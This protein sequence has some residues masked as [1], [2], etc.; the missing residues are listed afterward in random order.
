MPRCQGTNKDGTRCRNRVSEGAQ[1]CHAH[2]KQAQPNSGDLQA[3][4][5][6]IQ[7]PG[8]TVIRLQ[9]GLILLAAFLGAVLGSLVVLTIE[10]MLDSRRMAAQEQREPERVALEATHAARVPAT[11][12]PPSV[13]RSVG[14]E[15][16][17]DEW[18]VTISEVKRAEWLPWNNRKLEP[19]GQ[20]LIVYGVARN[21]TT[22][23]VTLFSSD[24]ELSIP[25]LIGEINVHRDATGAAGLQSGVERT[26]AG[27]MGVT[28][29]AGQRAPLIIAFDVP[30]V[31]EQATLR[32]VHTRGGIDLGSVKQVAMLP[33][34]TPPATWTPT[35]TNTPSRTNTPTPTNT[36]ELI[37]TLI[38]TTTPKP[39]GTPSPTST[40]ATSQEISAVVTAQG[41][42]VRA[43]PGISYQRV[44]TVV[45]GT[46][47]VLDL[48]NQ[49]GIWVRGRAPEEDL[50][51]WLSARYLRIDG[52][53][54]T[55]PV[56]ETG[57]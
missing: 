39:T 33:T 35:P 19:D 49:S 25:S 34:P 30:D 41:L 2:H 18:A 1:Y 9:I 21:P 11:Q 8:L 45:Q 36:P 42:S 24:F 26:V 44:G 27:F 20:W 22:I 56:A 40:S 7:E 3:P 31:A 48:R 46:E 37:T 23:P 53:V 4:E 38:P 32:F 43:G 14:E 10:G 54:M 28:L 12:T 51:G 5:T 29:K 52:D 16:R 55:L 57:P 15:V 50:Q 6:T 47:L 13:V 17:T